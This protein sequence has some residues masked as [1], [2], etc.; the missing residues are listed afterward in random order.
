MTTNNTLEVGDK[1]RC[2]YFGS[3]NGIV[4]I[5]KVT[6]KYAYTANNIYKFHL[7]VSTYND[8]SRVG[9][10]SSE[11]VHFYVII[12]DAEKDAEELAI[13][14]LKLKIND[15][16]RSENLKLSDLEAITKIIDGSN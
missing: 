3:T 1:I 16:I 10:K 7:N 9:D 15:Y 5:T 6:P 13:A 8:V 11:R 4:E 2:E 14:K 12:E